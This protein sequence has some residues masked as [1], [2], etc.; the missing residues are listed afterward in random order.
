MVTIAIINTNYWVLF[1]KKSSV[2][3]ILIFASF[4]YKNKVVYKKSA[5][6]A[7]CNI[8]IYMVRLG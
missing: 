4:A 8:N 6:N 3:I 5:E 7:Y 1:K 2:T